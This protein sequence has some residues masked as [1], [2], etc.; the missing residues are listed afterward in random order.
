[1][2]KRKMMSELNGGFALSQEKA[3]QARELAGLLREKRKLAQELNDIS[4]QV[5][6]QRSQ[7]LNGCN[8]KDF[9][10]ENKDD[11]F[12]KVSDRD[13]PTTVTL[14]DQQKFAPAVEAN[15]RSSSP[16]AAVNHIKTTLPGQ[17]GRSVTVS[18]ANVS[19][20]TPTRT[21]ELPPKTSLRT[22]RD[23]QMKLAPS[24]S[25]RSSPKRLSVRLQ[26]PDVARKPA[27]GDETMKSNLKRFH[28]FPNIAKLVEEGNDE[29]AMLSDAGSKRTEVQK[30][31]QAKVAQNQ[32]PHVQPPRVDRSVKPTK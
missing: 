16:P 4:K 15:D 28:S 21:Q 26:E 29:E 25:P 10:D 3:K 7:I 22:S 2:D 19:P 8:K 9:T 23:P 18:D 14:D 31:Q 1:M 11:N 12:L 27:S 30:S 20:K 6:V 24:S 17:V 32:R 13:S 5:Q